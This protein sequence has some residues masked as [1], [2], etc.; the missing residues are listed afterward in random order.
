MA[1]FDFGG[2]GSLLGGVGDIL[3]AF[4][5]G[6]SG[7]P[8]IGA[9][10]Q[11]SMQQLQMQEQFQR[12]MAQNSISW[13]VDDAKRAGISPLAALGAPTF[14]P[15]VSVPPVDYSGGGSNDVVGHLSRAGA[16]IGDALSKTFTN[17]D[18]ADLLYKTTVQQQQIKSNDL[19]IAI[20]GA[21][22][23]RL[24]RM[25]Q[26][27]SAPNVSPE[28]GGL[29]GQGMVKVVPDKQI[30][31]QS[32]RPDVTAGDHPDSQRF[33]GMG[34]SYT[35]P[36]DPAIINNPSVTNPFLWRWGIRQYEN[37]FDRN[38]TNPL[39]SVFGMPEYKRGY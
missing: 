39:R 34:G 17:S 6:R 27:P 16:N 12:E 5:V 29:A 38:V 7:G 21:Q 19:D 1:G 4:G 11:F 35:S 22:F 36:V 26:T 13:R 37:W 31:A 9:Q 10:Q 28:S 15:T 25:L 2:I 20:K 14:S 3:G 33:A 8:D 18:K 23:A 32:G 24:N 30:S